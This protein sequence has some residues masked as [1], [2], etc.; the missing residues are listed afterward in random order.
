MLDEKTTQVVTV[1]DFAEDRT[2]QEKRE[3]LFQLKRA[4]ELGNTVLLLNPTPV[5]SNLFDVLNRHFTEGRKGEYFAQLSI[6]GH[7]R[8]TF[9][10]K[11]F[12]LITVISQ[13]HLDS[14]RVKPAWLDRF[15]K[16]PVSTAAFFGAVLA[17][18]AIIAG[19]QVDHRQG[20][21]ACGE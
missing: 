4:M 18:T 15:H 6:D 5:S 17:K 7:S 9:V 13:E 2:P 12:R 11:K 8:P 16:I 10:H 19:C 20:A 21:R 14:Y 3:R 1:S